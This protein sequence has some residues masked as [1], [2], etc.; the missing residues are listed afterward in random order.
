MA[1]RFLVLAS[2][3]PAR[4][5]LMDA[6]GVP[7]EAVPPAV[8]ESVPEGT[9][10]VA[11]VAMLA[12]RKAEAVAAIRPG[13]LVIG[14]DQLVELDGAALGKPADREAAGAQLRRLRGRSHRII[15]GVC[16]VGPGVDLAEVDAVTMTVF[17][18]TEE[19]VEAYLDTGEWRGCA[20]GYREESRGQ[21]IFAGIEGDRTSVQ[22]LPMLRVVRLLR[23][24]GFPLLSA[25][26]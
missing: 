11:A 4:R 19:E 3:S 8:E 25:S 24:A 23:Q 17:P 21:A 2:T 1:D 6:L 26:Q 16:L 15:T 14:A 10:V 13:A 7:Y 18:L 12:R 22:G 5:Q 20:G 9:P